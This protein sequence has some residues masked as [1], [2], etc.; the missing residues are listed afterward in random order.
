M[1]TTPDTKP[2]EAPE[3]KV[4]RPVSGRR[5][6]TLPGGR[7]EPLAIFLARIALPTI[8]ILM[9]II[10]SVLRPET[11]FTLENLKTVLN[12]QSVLVILSL[13]LLLP[14]IVGEIDLSV[15]ANLGF[16]LIVVTGLTSQQGLPLPVAVLLAVAG[17]TI[18][19]W[20][21]GVMV[22]RLGMPSLIATLAMST[23]L[24]GVVS[25]YT[26]GGVFY[27]NIPA[28]LIT[29][30]QGQL[31]GVPLPI[32]Y[33]LL[34]AL[35]IWY[36][37]SSTP[38][39]R[40]LYAIGGSREAA[41]LSGVPVRRLTLL[42]FAGAGLLAGIAGVVQAGILGSGSPTVGPP[43]LLPV[44][45]AVFLGATAIQPGVFNVWG[46][47]IAVVTLQVGT[48]GLALLGAPFWIEPIFTGVALIIAVASA[49][50]LRGEAL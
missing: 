32:V 28:A 49:R 14:L 50:F 38:Q 43:Y 2:V 23:I 40:F 45:A 39:G 3:Q 21:N 7:S 12:L 20:L 11:F 46:T 18:V 34:I 31:F 29:I 37:L 26:G 17:C 5:L 9:V 25:A 16:G 24:L 48:T 44:F 33:A 4:R 47:I 19:G 10:F 15:A 6:I 27:D 41:R 13:G 8:L 30:G 22:T 42:A 35:I 1:T 36:V